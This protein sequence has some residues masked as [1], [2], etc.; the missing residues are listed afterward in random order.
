MELASNP[1]VPFWFISPGLWRDS[2]SW[3]ACLVSWTSWSQWTTRPASLRS[4]R[5][6]LDASKLSWTT[7]WAELM[8]WVTA[9]ALTSS[10]KVSPLTTSKPRC[11]GA[12]QTAHKCCDFLSLLYN[13]SDLLEG[14]GVGECR[15]QW[16]YLHAG[17]TL[18]TIHNDVN[19][20]TLTKKKYHKWHKTTSR[21]HNTTTAKQKKT[22]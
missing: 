13:E 14:G 8:S 12:T 7:L 11:T 4:T 2:L 1:N 17:V 16:L 18:D 5:R 6:W 9:R 10:H 22:K 20:T 15:Y 19:T 21:K 3:M